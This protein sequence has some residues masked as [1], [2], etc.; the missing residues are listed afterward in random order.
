MRSGEDRN[1]QKGEKWRGK[2]PFMRSHG[3]AKGFGGRGRGREG[4]STVCSALRALRQWLSV[5]GKWCAVV[6]HPWRSGENG[7]RGPDK[8]SLIDRGR[9]RAWRL[10]TQMVDSQA[11]TS[12]KGAMAGLRL[13]VV[14]TKT[15]KGM[16]K[17]KERRGA[18][19]LDGG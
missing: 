15:R 9:L 12:P 7:E 1:T 16:R 5:G 10:S 11:L 8:E 17:E 14:C 13:S 4:G 2:V 18:D 3:C 6:W 19:P